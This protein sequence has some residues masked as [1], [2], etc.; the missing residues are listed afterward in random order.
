MVFVVQMYYSQKKSPLVVIVRRLKGGK[1]P[2]AKAECRKM[3]TLWVNR[4]TTGMQ[5]HAA[6]NAD[7]GLYFLHLNLLK[8]RTLRFPPEE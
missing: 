1:V 3:E 2:Q 8:K 4:T 6:V 7:G 5:S